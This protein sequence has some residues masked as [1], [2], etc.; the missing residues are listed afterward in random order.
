MFQTIGETVPNQ[1][2]AEVSHLSVQCIDVNN[3]RYLNNLLFYILLQAYT[4]IGKSGLNLMEHR[5]LAKHINTVIFHTKMVDS[6][7][8]MLI[9]TSDL[10]IYWLVILLLLG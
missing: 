1:R 9:E 10:S 4:S 2:N 8:E 7:E 3:L 5:D 6:L